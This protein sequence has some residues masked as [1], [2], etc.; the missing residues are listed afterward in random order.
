MHTILH[1]RIFTGFLLIFYDSVLVICRHNFVT[2]NL[3][4]WLMRIKGRKDKTSVFISLASSFSAVGEMIMSPVLV[5][6]YLS[7]ILSS[8]GKY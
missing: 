4:H 8:N 2:V 1:T 3:V 5:P 6:S 7:I